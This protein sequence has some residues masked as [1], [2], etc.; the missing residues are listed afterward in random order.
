M[1]IL[2]S[3]GRWEG[4]IFEALLV[5]H[6]LQGVLWSF[7]TTPLPSCRCQPPPLVPCCDPHT[8]HPHI[9]ALSTPTGLR[10][11]A[12]Y[13]PLLAILPSLEPSRLAFKIDSLRSKVDL[14]K[15]PLVLSSKS[16][17]ECKSQLGGVCERRSTAGGGGGG[18]AHKACSLPTRD[19]DNESQYSGYS[20]KSSHSRSSRKHR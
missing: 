17:S 5:F 8:H 13:T 3:M 7:L 6:L 4:L 18:R 10:L 11:S 19:M 14:L 12:L 2:T 1:H 15:L 20:Y 16:I 9:P